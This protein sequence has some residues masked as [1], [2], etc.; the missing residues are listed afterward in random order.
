[1]SDAVTTFYGRWARLYD[2]V[3]RRTP[4][5]PAM[6][7]RTVSAL[8]LE[9]G[10]T[11]VEMGCGTGANFPHL[12][13]AVGPSGAV[14][15]LDLVDGMLAQARRRIDRQGWANVHTV[16]GDATRPPVDQVDAVVSTFLIGM[17]DDPASAVRDWIELVEPGGRI[18]I[19]NAGRSDRLLATPLNLAF[20]GFV[21]L[22]APGGRT[23][24]TSPTQ[25]LEARWER[26]RAALLDGTVEHDS[27]RLG[28]GF[29]VLAS[30]RVPD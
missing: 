29:V 13:A 7:G 28:M 5:I 19:M 26:A 10:D 30:G 3:A 25:A 8:D 18:T 24:R 21:R 9:A 6:R 4:G 27:D 15:G 11:V 12:R 20:R 2:L 16:R 17:L 22:A 1:M 23:M 14:V